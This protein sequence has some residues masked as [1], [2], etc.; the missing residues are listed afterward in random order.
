MGSNS[1]SNSGGG[2][3]NQQAKARRL[4]TTTPNYGKPKTKSVTA[5]T[6]SDPREKD[7]TAAKAS[8]FRE[9][10]ATNI[11]N[12]KV[13][14]PSVAILKGPLKA[15][16]RFNRD[17]FKNE[18]L[19]KG[20]YKGTSVKDFES[21]SRSAQES[22]YGGYMSGRTSGK[23]D[24]Y[25]NPISQGGNGGGAIESTGQVVQAPQP[26]TS[27]TTAEVSQATAADAQE[28]L[29]LRKRK[30][31]ARGRS[32]TIMTGVTGA[33]GSLTLGKPSLLGR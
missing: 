30:T 25:G 13:V 31:L 3:G 17:Y 19:G 7:D 22:L 18:V 27:P 9:Q 20:A 12:L 24:A 33:T 5:G 6:L 21:M 8:L 29:V 32:P 16:S 14:P 15:G 23:T 2:G 10:G 4:M 11:D 1:G 28:S 26:V